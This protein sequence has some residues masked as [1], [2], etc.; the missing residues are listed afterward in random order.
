VTSRTY[1]KASR[2]CDSVVR[3]HTVRVEQGDGK[4]LRHSKDETSDRWHLSIRPSRNPQRE[5]ERIGQD[6]TADGYAPVPDW[7]EST[8][9]AQFTARQ[10][11]DFST[12]MRRLIRA[13][14]PDAGHPLRQDLADALVAF[15]QL[16]SEVS[17]EDG[18]AWLDGVRRG[19]IRNW[20]ADQLPL[21]EG[22]AQ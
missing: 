21:T 18:D 12:L 14:G 16:L 9:T 3:T 2:R 5:A 6:L 19:E 7:H 4:V 11:I 8:Y 20:E 22:G 15:D 13:D 10:L 1:A 17:E